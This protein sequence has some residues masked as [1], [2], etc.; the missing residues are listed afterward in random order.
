MI[1]K[2]IPSELRYQ[3]MVLMRILAIMGE[4]DIGLESILQVFKYFLHLR[5]DERHKAVSKFLEHRPA[6][7]GGRGEQTRSASRFIFS[8]AD[9]AENNPMKQGV[10]VLFCKTKN[11]T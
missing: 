8:F 6:E 7:S 4:N 1:P 9:C 3:T 5:S 10:G 2:R 11:G